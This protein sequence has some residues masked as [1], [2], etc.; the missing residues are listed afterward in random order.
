[1]L[2]AKK[3]LNRGRCKVKES[4]MKAKTLPMFKKGGSEA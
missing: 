3:A 1:M 2:T 4:M